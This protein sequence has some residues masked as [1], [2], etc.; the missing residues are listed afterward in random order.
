MSDK[1]RKFS[2]SSIIETAADFGEQV[3]SKVASEAT[4][5]V[6]EDAQFADVLDGLL[7]TNGTKQASVNTGE[8]SDDQVREMLGQKIAELHAIN[9]ST[10]I[11]EAQVL[12]RAM[13]D[14]FLSRASEYEFEAQK[15]ASVENI[16]NP[17]LEKVA[18]E[19]GFNQGFEAVYKLAEAE[20]AA[21][22]KHAALEVE[23]IKVACQ[24]QGHIDTLN[25]L[26]NYS[27]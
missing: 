19:I 8:L 22:Q 2:L 5:K 23:Q 16:E 26:A 4:D 9:A 17:D 25:V 10:E 1:S 11:K 18:S 15:I 7:S 14:G 21:G 24:W 3:S 6:A 20:L 13:Y 12:G 27:N